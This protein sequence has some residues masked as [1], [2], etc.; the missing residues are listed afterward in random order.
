[1]HLDHRFD[2]LLGATRDIYRAHVEADAAR[3]ALVRAALHEDAREEV[4]RNAIVALTAAQKAAAVPDYIAALDDPAPFVASE[5]A[6]ALA[7]YGPASVSGPANEPALAALRGHA[8]RLRELLG[9][10]LETAR[11]NALS[12]LVAIADPDTAL[13]TVLGDESALVRREALELAGVRMLGAGDVAALGA[14]AARDPDAQLRVLAVNLVAARAPQLALPVL[15][16][17]LAR[18]DVDRSTANLV[19]DTQL[20]ALVPAILAYLKAN[21]KEPYFFA[22]LA[23]F[24]ATCAA[25]TIAQLANGPWNEAFAVDALAKLSGH[26]DWPRDKLFAWANAQRESGP[27]CTP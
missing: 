23:A 2:F 17:A 3:V 27:P 24:G 25:K 4:R 20:V 9:A 6:A 8:P 7:T 16:A 21:P 12:A 18:G 5:A 10:P 19:A 13:A 14:F 15:A 22:T 1:M 11:F 26:A